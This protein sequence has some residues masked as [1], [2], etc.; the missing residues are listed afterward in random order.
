[1]STSPF[2][3]FA[4]NPNFN[5]WLEEN[6]PAICVFFMSGNSRINKPDDD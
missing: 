1:M 4:A 5:N 6:Y 2:I 3:V